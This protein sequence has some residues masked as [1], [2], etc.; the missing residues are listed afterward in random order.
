M[1]D[2]DIS[3]AVK[4]ADNT[5]MTVARVED[6]IAGLGIR[7]SDRCAVAVLCRSPASVAYDVASSADVVENPIDEAG[8]VQ[9][10]GP[11]AAQTSLGVPQRESQP[12]TRLLPPQK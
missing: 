3:S 4:A 8:A 1:D 12:K 11:P 9:A 2:L 7:P 6:Q 5:H 10:V